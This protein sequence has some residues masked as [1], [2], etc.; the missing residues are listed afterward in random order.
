[1]QAMDRA[2]LAQVIVATLVALAGLIFAGQGLGIITGGSAM[3]GDRTW[4]V[5][6]A[7]LAVGGAWFAIR[8]WSRRR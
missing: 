4:V 3:V 5:I 6:G 8:A 1:M 7:A 2:R